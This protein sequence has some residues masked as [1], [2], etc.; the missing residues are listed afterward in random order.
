MNQNDNTDEAGFPAHVRKS[1][2]VE[3]SIAAHCAG[4][5]RLAGENAG[6]LG[7]SHAAYLLGLLHD[8]GKACP[9]FRDYLRSATGARDQDSDG[10]VDAARMKGKI[11]H[12]TAAAQ[13]LWEQGVARGTQALPAAQALALCLAS[14]HSGLIDCLSPEGQDQ[15]RRRVEKPQSETHL[16]AALTNLPGLVTEAQ[17]RTL[18][19]LKELHGRFLEITTRYKS[20]DNERLAAF[21][22]G[23]LVRM[24]LGC[25]LDADRFD[26]AA[27]E[28]PTLHDLRGN[29]TPDWD[30]LIA[31]HEAHLAG[32]PGEGRVN[33]LRRRISD[34]CRAH[35]EDERGLFT[36]TVPTGGGKTHAGLRFAL[37][38]A[39]KHGLKRII[40]VIPYTSI[41]DQNAAAARRALE[42][43][44]DAGR[45]VLEHHSNLEPERDTWTSKHL[46]ETWDAP[47]IFTTMVQFLETAFGG[48]MRGARRLPR[49]CDAVIVFDEAQTLPIRCV[50]LFCN[51]VNFLVRE[52]GS[53]VV[54]CTATQPLLTKVDAAKGCIDAPVEMMN[55]PDRLFRELDRVEIIDRTSGNRTMTMPEIADLALA[56]CRDL[57]NCLVVVNTK[58]A[59]MELFRALAAER[60]GEVFH[61]STDMCAHHRK[62]ILG[63][64]RKRLD[65]KRPAL[66]ISTQLIEAGV[67]IDFR[68]VIRFLAGLDSIAQAAGR[69]NRNGA[70]DKGRVH[71]VTPE[72]ESLSPL[73]DI[74]RGKDCTARVLRDFAADPES[75]GGNLLHPL[76]M[77]RYFKYAFHDCRNDMDY[78]VDTGR[79]D[80]L[81]RILAD[82][83]K[84]GGNMPHPLM[85]RQS[86]MTAARAFQAI[87]APTEGVIVPYGAGKKIIAELQ[88]EITPEQRRAL[89]RRAQRY[90]V[91][92]FPNRKR[93]L[94]EK[95]ALQQIPDAE[96]LVLDERHYSREFGLS[97]EPVEPLSFLEA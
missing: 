15:F 88:A 79:D 53:S 40:H 55:D 95:G 20:T 17:Q 52:C 80:T 42:T 59:A 32:F 35:A 81:L 41:I 67:D 14:H 38:H 39:R 56:E 8:W 66:C 93:K 89:L 11:D 58:Q 83:G 91:N 65:L 22:R 75:L 70:A 12:S 34:D 30:A 27:F 31:R 78:P 77:G 68:A 29:G 62:R 96:T 97:D 28:F 72:A 24:L 46:G 2:G 51:V 1:D 60:P 71:I 26:S 37:H 3:Q 76:A 6:P 57:G 33:R 82:N 21:D 7:L 5:A 50:H 48:G 63:L 61:L 36:L 44:N 18:P 45:I 9:E 54:L 13:W 90:S 25:L 94:Q 73:P 19:A 4:V 16:A 74:A 64:V 87:D 47:V 69:C 84:N 86:F 10:F 49:L 92:L 43:G 85:L 23:F